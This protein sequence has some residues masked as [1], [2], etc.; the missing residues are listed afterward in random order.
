VVERLVGPK[1]HQKQNGAATVF[2]DEPDAGWAVS[3][4]GRLANGKQNQTQGDA[5]FK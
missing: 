1:N 3:G 5:C 4:A 2:G